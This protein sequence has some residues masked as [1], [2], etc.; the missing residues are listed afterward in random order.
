MQ[1]V[2]STGEFFRTFILYIAGLLTHESAPGF[3]AFLLLLSL[4][5]AS[6]AFWRRVNK[7]RRAILWLK[8]EISASADELEFSRN[9]DALGAKIAENAKSPQQRQ[10]AHAWTEYRETFVPHEEDG[11]IIL[12]NAVRPSTFLNVEDLGSVP[13]LGGLHPACS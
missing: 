13:A 4:L 8:R 9:I 6:Y 5:F 7:Q 10:L 11:N 2:I 3:I 12:R 1:I